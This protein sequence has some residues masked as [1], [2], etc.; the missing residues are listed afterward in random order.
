MSTQ[1]LNFS[2]LGAKPVAKPL[3]FSDLG[4]KPVSGGSTT[5]QTRKPSIWER[6][7]FPGPDAAAPLAAG[8]QAGPS[9]EGGPGEMLMSG[10]SK[11]SR[12]AGKM[13]YEQGPKQMGSGVMDVTRGDIAR[14]GSKIIRGGMVTALPLAPE[15]IATNPIMAARAVAGGYVGSKFGESVAEV[16]GAN[17]EQKQFAGDIG[18]LAGGFA[19]ASGLPRALFETAAKNAMN[20]VATSVSGSL[21]PDVVGLISPRLA[22]LMRIA[23]NV[24]EVAKSP[25]EGTA[26]GPVPSGEIAPSPYRLSGNQIVNPTTVTPRRILGADRMLTEGG[27]EI[28]PPEEVSPAPYRLAGKQ[29]VDATTVTPRRVLGPERQLNAAPQ[30]AQVTAKPSGISQPTVPNATY[31]RPDVKSLSQQPPAAPK[32]NLLSGIREHEFLLKVQDELNRQG[33]DEQAQ[34]EID[35]WIE[36][37]NQQA[38]GAKNPAKASFEAQKA[39]AES[40]AKAVSGEPEQ[41]GHAG[42]GVTSVEELNRPGSNYVVSKSGQL[43]YHG[44]AFDPGGIPPGSTHVTALPDGTIRVNAGPKLNPAQEMALKAALPK[45]P[46]AVPRVPTSDAD[47]EELLMQSLQ[48]VKARKA[49]AGAD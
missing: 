29:I 9:G 1:P 31:L 8:E 33:G 40:K 16:S 23:K 22:H 44:K 25:V 41:G 27:P 43:T 26:A 28:V 19:A 6:M 38:P 35:K 21:D 12:E 47:M 11:A 37:H 32:P 4:G 15:A 20:E 49:Q 17:P 10:L 42:G 14:G 13:Y 45:R 18:N 46:A 34:A 24:A 39:A 5:G 2:D 3:D 30:A 7:G 48:Q 36:A